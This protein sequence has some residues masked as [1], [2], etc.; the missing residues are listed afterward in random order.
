MITR[1]VKVNPTD[2]VAFLRKDSFL[3]EG[4]FISSPVVSETKVTP[5]TVLT[6][7]D[8]KNNWVKVEVNTGN[9]CGS[10]G[11]VQESM[12]IKF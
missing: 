4:N 9:S 11:W 1:Y 3:R 10:I 8:R 2:Q 6:I 7:I 5:K 12:V